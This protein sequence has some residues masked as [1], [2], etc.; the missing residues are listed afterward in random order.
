MELTD[1]GVLRIEQQ[2]IH[3]LYFF[4]Q[5]EGMSFEDSFRFEMQLQ[6]IELDPGSVTAVH[7]PEMP[8]DD[9]PPEDRPAILEAIYSVIRENDPGFGIW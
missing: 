3:Y 9:L 2:D 8:D 4:L 7:F 5:R 6:G 1:Q